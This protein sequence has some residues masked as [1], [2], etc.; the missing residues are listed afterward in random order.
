MNPPETTHPGILSHS[1]QLSYL[2]LTLPWSHSGYLTFLFF[3]SGAAPITSGQFSVVGGI[4]PMASSAVPGYQGP[5]ASRFCSGWVKGQGPVWHPTRGHGPARA[6]HICGP[7]SAQ[8]VQ[9]GAYYNSLTP[10]SPRDWSCSL[11]HI[12]TRGQPYLSPNPKGGNISTEMTPLCVNIGMPT[13][14]ITAGSRGALRDPHPPMLLSV[15]MCTMP[16]WAQ[17]CHVPSAPLCSLTPMP[18]NGMA[19]RHIALGLQT[20]LKG[21]YTHVYTHKKRIVI[22]TCMFKKKSCC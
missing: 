7:V 6:S 16:I 20:Q 11:G 2:S 5:P 21:C 22:E 17:S 12:R 10:D 9:V 3:F 13:G 14:S 19:S 18:S 1:I 4:T 8:E 15:C